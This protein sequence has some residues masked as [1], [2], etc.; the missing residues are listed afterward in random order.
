MI[1]GAP[2][3]VA[4]IEM[5]ERQISI[6]LLWN[7]RYGFFSLKLTDENDEVLLEG[8]AVKTGCNMLAPYRL[9]LGG[10]FVVSQN[11]SEEMTIDN[12]GVSTFLVHLDES[13]LT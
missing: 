8:V 2:K 7:T 6:S 10:L 13:E 3:Q 9:G 5:E 12:I 1:T 11:L 4:T